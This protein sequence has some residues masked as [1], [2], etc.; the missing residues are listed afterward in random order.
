MDDD[1]AYALD[2]FLNRDASGLNNTDAL[3]RAI[4]RVLDCAID[5]A[6]ALDSDR[7]RELRRS[8]QQLKAELPNPDKGLQRFKTWWQAQGQTWT[9]LLSAAIVEHNNASYDWQFSNQ[10]KHLLRQY[11]DANKLLVDCLNSDC[12]VT[13]AVRSH[14]EDTLLLPIAAIEKLNSL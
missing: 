11:Y 13:P 6:L 5:F 7:A 2:F 3:D 4:N 1:F 8:L 14:I 12:E 9:E 10:Q